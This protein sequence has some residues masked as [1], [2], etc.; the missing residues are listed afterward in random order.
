MKW[1]CELLNSKNKLQSLLQLTV[2]DSGTAHS[3]HCHQ[4]DNDH[5]EDHG[6]NRRV[7]DQHRQEVDDAKEDRH[8]HSDEE[9]DPEEGR[10]VAV[11]DLRT[12][13]H[14]L[15]GSNLFVKHQI[16]GL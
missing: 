11:S 9:V 6:N 1:S 8:H 4:R 12:L 13:H 14:G 16:V 2:C 5:H 10:L 3:D 7:G 15:G